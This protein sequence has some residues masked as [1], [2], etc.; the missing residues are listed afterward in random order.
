M[1]VQLLSGDLELRARLAL[2]NSPIYELRD[3]EVEQRGQAIILSG[4]VSSFY[5]KQLAQ[6][7]VRSA[8]RDEDID[9]INL[10]EVSRKPFNDLY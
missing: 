2:Q 5:H 4:L 3:I 6:E 8:L 9:L 7:A 1:S 10:I